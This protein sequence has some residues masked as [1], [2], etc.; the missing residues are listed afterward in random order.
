MALTQSQRRKRAIAFKKSLMKR[1]R[2][3]ER[4]KNKKAPEEVLL[5]RAK[6]KAK[7]IVIIKKKILPNELVDKYPNNL[8]IP[9]KVAVEDKLKENRKLVKKVALKILKLLKRQ[10][11]EKVL[12]QSENK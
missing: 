2:T 3:K 7:K 12:K 1:L 10:E 8:S 6:Q 9:Q 5:R 11:A 4:L